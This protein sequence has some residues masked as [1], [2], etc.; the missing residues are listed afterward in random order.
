MAQNNHHVKDDVSKQMKKMGGFMGEFRQFAMRGNVIDLAV[1]VII[2]GAF[3]KI[4]SSV[5]SDLVMPFVGLFTGGINFTDQFVVLKYPD[6]VESAT[7]ATLKVATDAGATTFNYG[8]FITEVINFIIMAFVVFLLV[9]GINRLTASHKATEEEP[10]PTTKKCPF[11]CSEISIEAT[12][13]PHCTSVLEE[14]P[15]ESA[16]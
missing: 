9:K 12:R 3:Q 15:T 11:C 14:Q 13:C 5:V 6:G 7:Y 1:G 10:A 4:V 16:E 2:G 8:A